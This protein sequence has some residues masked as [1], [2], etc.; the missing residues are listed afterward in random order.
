MNLTKYLYDENSAWRWR[1]ADHSDLDGIM[2]IAR[3]NFQQEIDDIFTADEAYYRY[4]VDLAITTQQHHW[5]MGQFLVA[6]LRDKIIAYTWI[7]RGSCP[8]Y[9]QDTVAEARMLHIDLS[10]S[11]R[12]RIMLT[13]QTLINWQTW[14]KACAIP[15]LVSATIRRDQTAFM[16]LHRDMGFD[17]RGSIAYLRLL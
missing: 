8:P 13:V 12:T 15:V 9:S 14:A 10:Q 6:E 2:A 11:A 7:S 4:Q 17:V 1:V 16:R 5:G 3:L